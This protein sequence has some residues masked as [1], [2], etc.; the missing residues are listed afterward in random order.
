MKVIESSFEVVDEIDPQRIMQ[1]LEQIGRVSHQSKNKITPTSADKFIGDRL[2]K[3]A[4]G[5]AHDGL[6]EHELLTVRFVCDRKTSHQ[7]VRYRIASFCQESSRN[8][9]YDEGIPVINPPYWSQDSDSHKVWLRVMQQVE[10]GY[11]ELRALGNQPEAAALVLTNSTKTEVFASLNF[12]SWRNVFRQR[13][14]KRADLGIRQL[15]TGLRDYLRGVL[16]VI[17]GDV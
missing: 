15:M 9:N 5:I 17:F 11:N 4:D 14:G 1:K 10:D 3:D 13:C 2:K 16:P 7:L 6:L 8:C 12:R